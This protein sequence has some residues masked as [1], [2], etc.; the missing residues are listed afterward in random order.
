MF[1]KMSKFIHNKFI[2]SKPK[3]GYDVN[4][5]GK[6]IDDNTTTDSTNALINEIKNG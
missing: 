1:T 5:S 2:S 3:C 4:L 6:G